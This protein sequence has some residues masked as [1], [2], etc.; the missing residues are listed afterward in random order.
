MSWFVVETESKRETVAQD[1]IEE[2]GLHTVLF[3]MRRTKRSH[4]RQSSPFT[5][6]FPRYLFVEF[7][8][9]RDQ[10]AWKSIRRQRGVR[11]LLGCTMNGDVQT[12]P[13]PVRDKDFQ[14]LQELAAEMMID[15]SMENTR[16][17][18][19]A[20]DTVVRVLWGAMPGAIGKIEFDNGIR[21]DV[22]LMAAGVVSKI[23]LPRELI[24]AL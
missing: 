1:C 22:L 5:L 24:E 11:A 8:I 19:L 9:S 3:K 2:L 16:P 13:S 17:I 4:M 18:P 12:P 23:S 14:R 21:A 6:I 15:V 10:Y 20:H 7:D